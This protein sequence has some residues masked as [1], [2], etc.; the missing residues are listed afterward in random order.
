[1]DWKD[2]VLDAAYAVLKPGFEIF[3][4]NISHVK[5]E[6]RIY[7]YLDKI[8]DQYGSPTIQDCENFSHLFSLKLGVLE[9]KNEILANYS[10]EVSSPGAERKI[11]LPDDLDRFKEHPMRVIYHDDGK[12]KTGILK[13]LEKREYELLWQIADVKKN[14]K[15]GLITKR[16]KGEN[17]LIAISDIK[18]VNLH[19]DF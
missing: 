15:N 3:D 7:I 8:T 10:V 9:Q 16:N 6:P 2:K 13:L 18:R 12:V 1:M 17:V 4:M 11:R 19:L 14:R 5:G